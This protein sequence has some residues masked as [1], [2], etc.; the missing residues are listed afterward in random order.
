MGLGDQQ[1]ALR[2][3]QQGAGLSMGLL[4]HYLLDVAIALTVSEDNVRTSLLLQVLHDCLRRTGKGIA[5]TSL[6]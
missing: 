5:G 1:K 4:A 3:Q 6:R 2:C